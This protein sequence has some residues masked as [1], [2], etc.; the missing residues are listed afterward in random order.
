MGDVEIL[1]KNNVYSLITLK[2]QLKIINV[3][4]SARILNFYNFELNEWSK[5]NYKKNY[6]YI[7]KHVL[8]P[9]SKLYIITM[10][11]KLKIS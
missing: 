9:F 2:Y 7:I 10:I 3:I 11:F 5:L 4:T 6:C 1:K 8:E